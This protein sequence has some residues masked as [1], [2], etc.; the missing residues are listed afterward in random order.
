MRLG[1][2]LVLFT[3]AAFGGDTRPNATAHKRVTPPAASTAKNTPP[4]AEIER[5][6]R[7]RLA[8]SKIAADKF[9]VTVRGGVATFEGRTDVLQH[10][11]VATRMAKAAGARQVINKIQVSDAARQRAS[12]NLVKGRRRAQVKRSEAQ[13]R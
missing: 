8:K 12:E 5:D 9:Q 13:R 3:L 11:G 6:I 1:T 2:L 10:K 4:D 7:V